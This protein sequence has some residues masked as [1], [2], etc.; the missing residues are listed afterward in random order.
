[1]IENAEKYGA[2]MML[3]DQTAMPHARPADGV[4]ETGLAFVTLEPPRDL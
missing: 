4:R 2:Y 3:C 1:M